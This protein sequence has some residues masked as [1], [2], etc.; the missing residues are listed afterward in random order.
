MSRFHRK[1][2]IQR[3]VGQKC[4]AG[5]PVLLPAVFSAVTGADALLEA[6]ITAAC[7]F[8]MLALAS[9]AT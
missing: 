8:W 4:R 7:F 6:G 3:V 5:C 1:N 9:P 2:G